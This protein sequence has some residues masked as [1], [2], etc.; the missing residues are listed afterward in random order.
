[1]KFREHLLK[2]IIIV[3]SDPDRSDVTVNPGREGEKK[4][5]KE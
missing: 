1:L 4:R 5:K 2:Y 3:L